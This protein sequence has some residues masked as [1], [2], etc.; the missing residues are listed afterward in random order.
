M[1]LGEESTRTYVLNNRVK[2]V[3]KSVMKADKVFTHEIT[4]KAKDV[5]TQPLNFINKGSVQKLI[6]SL[7]LD[8]DQA[9]LLD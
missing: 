6:E 8:V 4:V 3:V 5:T 7:D 2:V 9:S 1:T